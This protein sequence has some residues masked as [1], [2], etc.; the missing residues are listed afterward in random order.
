MVSGAINIKKGIWI[1][2]SMVLLVLVA[3]WFQSNSLRYLLFPPSDLFEPLS[4]KKIDINNKG[5]VTELMFINKY[6][7]N[8]VIGITVEKQ[9]PEHYHNYNTTLEAEITISQNG[10]ELIT[11]HITKPG[12]YWGGY[13]GVGGFELMH[14]KSP[15]ELPLSIPLTFVIKV[16]ELDMGF[17]KTFGMPEIY[18]AK[19]SDK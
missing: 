14:Y 2:L 17:V 15:E 5:A 12:A 13:N 8:H 1:A 7:G 9:P 11:K 4:K 6:R 18:I 10:E 16:T 19:S 3:F